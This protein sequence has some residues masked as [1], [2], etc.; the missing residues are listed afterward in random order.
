MSKTYFTKEDLMQVRSNLSQLRP[1]EKPINRKEAV[2]KLQPQIE[3][4]RSK[5]HTLQDV[6]E[7]L[8]KVLDLYI[9]TTSLRTY[10]A[11]ASDCHPKPGLKKSRKPKQSQNRI[12]GKGGFE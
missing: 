11:E 9:S 3:S 10:L 7:I 8:G 12:E 1:K 6:T 4:L 2:I 5:G